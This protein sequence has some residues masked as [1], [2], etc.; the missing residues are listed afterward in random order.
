[1]FLYIC[2]LFHVVLSFLQTVGFMECV[3]VCVRARVRARACYTTLLL[4]AECFLKFIACAKKWKHLHWKGHF[5][6]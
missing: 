4:S 5:T 6:D 1:V 3:C 2:D